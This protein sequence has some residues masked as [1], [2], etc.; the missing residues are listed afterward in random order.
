[1]IADDYLKLGFPI[2]SRQ[3]LKCDLIRR[4]FGASPQARQTGPNEQTGLS[5]CHFYAHY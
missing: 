3:F 1:L 2:F 4:N 5:V